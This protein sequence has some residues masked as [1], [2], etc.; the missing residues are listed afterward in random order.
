MNAP[1]LTTEF[2]QVLNDDMLEQEILDHVAAGT[3]SK[4]KPNYILYQKRAN[5]S[6]ASESS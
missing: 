3:R 2:R 5:R 1:Y 4:P 6:K